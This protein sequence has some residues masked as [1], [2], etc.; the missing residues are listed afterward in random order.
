VGLRLKLAKAQR[1]HELACAYLQQ[2]YLMLTKETVDLDRVMQFLDKAI[3]HESEAHEIFDEL[4]SVHSGSTHV[5]RSYG[6]LLRDIYR[7]DETALMM[8]NEAN[9][10]EEETIIGAGNQG[11]SHQGGTGHQMEQKS[12][13]SSRGQSKKVGNKNGRVFSGANGLSKDKENLIPMFLP[14][15]FSCMVI[16]SFAII[17]A[18][19]LANIT[20]QEGTSTAQTINS[21]TD[22]TV[23]CFDAILY[24]KF[25]TTYYDVQDTSLGISLEGI[26]CI[27]SMELTKTILKEMS[28]QIKEYVHDAYTT[29]EDSNEFASWEDNDYIY[30]I[31][32]DFIKIAGID[33]KFELN[34]MWESVTNG[35][36]LFSS[37]SN[38]FKDFS[39]DWWDQNL[40]ASISWQNF[41]NTNIPVI[42]SEALKRV[43]GEYSDNSDQES[44]QAIIVSIVI[45]ALAIISPIVIMIIE[46]VRTITKLRKERHLVFINFCM[47][48]KEELLRLKKRLDD[49]MKDENEDDAM[50]DHTFS[51]SHTMTSEAEQ[52]SV[53]NEQQADQD[54]V[55]VDIANELLDVDVDDNQEGNQNNNNKQEDELNLEKQ[56]EQKEIKEGG[57]DAQQVIVGDQQQQVQ[58]QGEEKK[59]E[60]GI[61]AELLAEQEEDEER[62]Q[63]LTQ[64]I[65]KVKQFI[66]NNFYIRVI[67][68]FTIIVIFPIAFT[69]IAVLSAINTVSYSHLIFLTGYRT[70]LMGICIME[71]LNIAVPLRYNME[72]HQFVCQYSTNPVWND[73]SHMSTNR[74]EQQE[75]LKGSLQFVSSINQL[76]MQGSNSEYITASGDSFIDNRNCKRS[77]IAGS[78]TMEIQYGATQCFEN[79]EGDCDIENR[80][81]GITGEFKGLEALFALFSTNIITV[82]SANISADRTSDPTSGSSLREINPQSP[83]VQ[84]L[85]SL[86]LFDMS[87]GLTQY[88]SAVIKTVDESNSLF[89]TLLILFF[90]FGIVAILCGYFL[91]IVPT[92]S[93]LYSVA[94]GTSKMKDLDP[95]IDAALRT[96]M[97]AAGWKD[98]YTSDCPRFDREHQA[99]LL[100]LALACGSID[101]TMH[102]RDKVQE[103]STS[104][105]LSEQTSAIVHECEHLFM[106]KHTHHGNGAAAEDE[107]ENEDQE[108]LRKRK[109]KAIE[110]SL[111]MLLT[112]TFLCFEDEEKLIIH[113]QVPN[114]HKNPHFKQHATLARKLQSEILQICAILRGKGKQ[115]GKQGQKEE[116][117][118]KNQAGQQQSDIPA[119]HAKTLMQMYSGWLLDHVD[120]IDRELHAILVG[121]A[122]QSELEKEIIMGNCGDK[123]GKGTKHNFKIPHSLVQF[124]DSENASIQDRAAFERVLKA[125]SIR[126]K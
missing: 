2:A 10:I 124:L 117:L 93:I 16:N 85:M 90:V 94:R 84:S 115:K 100:Y 37:L 65:S 108:A 96:G 88:R 26:S 31:H 79:R 25:F 66:P 59:A 63:D 33:N 34:T 55:D 97:G 123:V 49:A 58:Q 42:V 101:T 92:K 75:L 28:S 69:V 105:V 35:I 60:D 29:T 32:F 106:I 1:G 54:V 83:E 56:K 81:Y 126:L 44:T 72:L 95:A 104:F 91:C 24:A 21:C 6:A 98:E 111:R 109:R 103:M 20:F 13:Q 89:N 114:S 23:T 52:Q 15:I 112:S 74:I 116:K 67:V 73:Q 48:E 82:Y 99:V 9:A 80:V 27:P 61:D 68:G 41:I 87:G 22:L 77:L 70:G 40:V 53:N 19:V 86:M 14:L 7:D 38:I 47:T 39:S 17:L 46:F 107:G 57:N 71:V 50:H 125:L 3:E 5:L 64:R 51:I 8:F 76:V 30:Q 110:G 45:S 121:K 36:D 119:S 43:C 11:G 113:Y 62:R 12:I 18:F 122:P 102:V 118:N 4:L 120:R 78:E